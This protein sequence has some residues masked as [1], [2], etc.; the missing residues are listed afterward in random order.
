V[1][2]GARLLLIV[3]ALAAT[4][5]ATM[6]HAQAPAPV[7]GK[8]F[9]AL[10]ATFDAPAPA[11]VVIAWGDG[12][13]QPSAVT[14][15]GAGKGEVTAGHTYA[16]HGTYS[17]QVTDKDNPDRYQRQTVTVAD[18]PITAQGTTFKV[19]AAPR[20]IVVATVADEN[21]LGTAADFTARIDWGDTSQSDAT[22][23]AVAGQAGRYEVRAAHIYPD[24]S[25]YLA[26]VSVTSTDGGDA[27]ASAQSTADGAPE[28]A[29][30][31][32]GRVLDMGRGDGPSMAVDDEGTAD[33]VWGVPAPGRTG[34]AVIFCRLP[35]GAR[36]CSVKRRFLVDALTAPVI[37]RDRNGVLRILV[38]YNGTRQIGG[39]T[40]IVSSLD[41][42]ATWDYRFF[43]VNT[44][45]F[46]GSIIDAALSQDGRML[47]ALFGDFVP[48]DKSQVF[49]AIGL[50]RPVLNREDDPGRIAPLT[51][52]ATADKARLV[53]SAR[54][55]GVLPDGR[56]VIAGYDTDERK[57]TP[58]AAIRVM[59][60]AEGNP[61]TAPWTP[62]RG[63]AVYGL[64]SSLR[65]A[66]LIGALSCAKGVEVAPLRNLRLGAARPLSA[67]RSLAC[68]DGG[69]A[70]LTYDSAG[71][72]HAAW[73][74]DLDGCPGSK[75]A[76]DNDNVCIISRRARPGGD[77]GAKT[78]IATI[79]QSATFIQAAAG[80]DGEGWVLWRELVDGVPKIRI[81]PDRVDAEAAVGDR[82][83]IA[84]TFKPSAECAKD[85]PVTVGAQAVGPVA[86]RPRILGVT[87]STTPG[88]LPRR[89]VD[90]T[91]PFSTRLTVDRRPFKN[92]SSSGVIVFGMTVKAQV[93]YRVGGKAVRV[94][95]L[96]QPLSFF[97]GI[98]F[99]RVERRRG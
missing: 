59:A 87:W 17:L 54:T 56:A 9:T 45:V 94:A 93:R 12:S 58:R 57:R 77:F 96:R 16:K 42:G 14:T 36:A 74:W 29:G 27:K 97:C 26:E 75:T 48:G 13:T 71:G 10:L 23:T 18:A 1:S 84:L 68:N 22:L 4:G 43:R 81:T 15:D 83:R 67:D 79:D 65:G 19:A 50:D 7:E 64:A 47:Y 72:R 41:D 32:T 70:D 8:P 33:V 89:Q 34:D 98:P 63:G 6:A 55:V 51:G 76:Y 78:V 40:L 91:A 20:G 31:A 37:L 62:I 73:L 69:G 85:G 49:A 80:K 99:S 35:R 52:D 30:P 5:P 92:L 25:S 60:D 38:S 24:A 11:Q 46:Q 95:R 82:H 2:R 39:G 61:V 90:T 3:L 86:G 28:P 88:L 21:T 44:G 53:Y 66:S